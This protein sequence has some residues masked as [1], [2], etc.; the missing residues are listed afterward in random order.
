MDTRLEQI[1]T[2][3]NSLALR[4]FALIDGP[5]DERTAWLSDVEVAV[6][7]LYAAAL[8]LPFTEPSD[9]EAP[10][11]PVAAHQRLMTEI[12]NRVGETNFYEFVFHPLQLKAGPV[13]G[14]LAEDLSSIYEDLYAGTALMDAHVAPEDVVWTWRINFKIHWGR[15]ALGA[16]LALGDALR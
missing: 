3:F 14:S 5:G 13:V 7:D 9:Q 15:H 8:R 1:I 11:L 2:Q 12:T 4:Y 6:A 10:G 16:L